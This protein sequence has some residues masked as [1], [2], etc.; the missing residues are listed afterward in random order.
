VV[1]V[2][3][4]EPTS[5]IDGGWFATCDECRWQS[6]PHATEDQANQAADQH[7]LAMGR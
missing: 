4:Q 6:G 1:Y 7:D 2:E 5:E 3:H